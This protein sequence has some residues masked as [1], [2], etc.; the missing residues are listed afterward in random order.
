MTS[1]SPK[2]QKKLKRLPKGRQSRMALRNDSHLQQSR[3]FLIRRFLYKCCHHTFRWI[4]GAHKLRR[5]SKPHCLLYFPIHYSA[6]DN[7]LYQIMIY[8]YVMRTS[9]MMIFSIACRKSNMLWSYHTLSPH[10]C[11]VELAQSISRVELVQKIKRIA[12]FPVLF[13]FY[14]DSR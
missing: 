9:S 6:M 7:L 11:G 5:T 3:Q 12:S 10:Y 13:F 1:K 2:L 14:A 8:H 4:F